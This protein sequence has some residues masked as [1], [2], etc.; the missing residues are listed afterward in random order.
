V[1]GGERRH[2]LSAYLT[3]VAVDLDGKPRPVPPLQPET[4]DERR[5]Y[6]EADLRRASR[7]QHAEELKRLRA[8]SGE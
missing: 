6:A 5:R 2:I 8:Q 3:F 4:P 1:G 7:L